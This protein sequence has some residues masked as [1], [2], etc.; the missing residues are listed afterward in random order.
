MNWQFQKRATIGSPDIGPSQTQ[1]ESWTAKSSGGGAAI[2][3]TAITLLVLWWL[4]A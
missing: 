1:I 4:L 3:W 2:A